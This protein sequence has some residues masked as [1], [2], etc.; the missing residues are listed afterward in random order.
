MTLERRVA[1][2]VLPGL[3]GL[4]LVTAPSAAAQATPHRSRAR[5]GP[6]YRLEC[7]LYGRLGAH[8][9]HQWQAVSSR[10]RLPSHPG[11]ASVAQAQAISSRPGVEV[12]TSG[13]V[14]Q[15]NAWFETLPQ[16]SRNVALQIGPGD[17]VSIDVHELAFDLWQVTIVDGQ[18]VFQIE[19]PYTSSHSSAEWIVE[20]PSFGTWANTPGDGHRRQLRQYDDDRQRAAYGAGAA[21]PADDSS[22]WSD[23][24]SRSVPLAIGTGRKQLRCCR[25]TL[26]ERK[27]E[28]MATLRVLNGSG[29]RQISW[30][31]TGLARATPRHK[32]PCAKRSASSPTNGNSW[33]CF[34]RSPGRPGGTNRC[35]RPARR[36]HGADSPDGRGLNPHR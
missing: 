30:S 17:W 7:L 2:L 4:L 6:V 19:I 18:Q 12:D 10:R 13:P 21:V 33:G 35:I 11:L 25:H 27:D 34:S 26:V 9:D 31:A 32:A 15:Y 3:L 14:T 23:R 36:G 20:D 8:P 1:L 22:G 24:S 28:T 16:A 29:D 5:T